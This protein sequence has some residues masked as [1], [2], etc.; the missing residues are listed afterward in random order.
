MPR[1]TISCLI[2]ITKKHRPDAPVKIVAADTQAAKTAVLLRKN[3]T[4]LKTA[5]DNAITEIKADG[6]YQRIWDKYFAEGNAE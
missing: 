3:D 4:E 5:V 1:S 2:S 6:T